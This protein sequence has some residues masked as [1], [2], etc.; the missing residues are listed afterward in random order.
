MT[1]S[2][3]PIPHPLPPL[4]PKGTF[5]FYIQHLSGPSHVLLFRSVTHSHSIGHHP[6]GD[7]FRFTFTSL[8]LFQRYQSIIPLKKNLNLKGSFFISQR[9]WTLGAKFLLIDYSRFVFS[10]RVERSLWKGMK[11]MDKY[12]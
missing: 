9:L 2:I 8:S 10:K 11:G 5:L 6:F 12:C 1:T 3:P 7:S 4:S